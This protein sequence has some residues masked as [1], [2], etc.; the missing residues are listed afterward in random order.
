MEAYNALYEQYQTLS[1]QV[2]AAKEFIVDS[3]A[4]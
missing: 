1:E 3:L 4:A 2:N